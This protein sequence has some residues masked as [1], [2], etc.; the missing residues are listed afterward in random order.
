MVFVE[1]N[2]KE[3]MENNGGLLAGAVMGAVFGTA[4]GMV[5][6]GI[7]AGVVGAN[8]GTYEEV[9]ETWIDCT[10]KGF[11]GGLITGLGTSI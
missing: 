3:A 4:A 10:K 1:L 6:G 8:G 9:N 11:F 7:A 5:I 2:E